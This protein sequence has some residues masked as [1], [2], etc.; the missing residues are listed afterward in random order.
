MARV[1]ENNKD[2]MYR[3]EILRYQRTLL[4]ELIDN[5]RLLYGKGEVLQEYTKLLDN[6]NNEILDL[7]LI[8]KEG[9]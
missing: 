2:I 6:L 9:V 1:N 4:E 7:M 5:D 3:L 8:M